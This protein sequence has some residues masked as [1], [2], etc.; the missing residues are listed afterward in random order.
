MSHEVPSVWVWK[1]GREK[2]CVCTCA[3]VPVHTF[4][5]GECK[6]IT[7]KVSIIKRNACVSA[8]SLMN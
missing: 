5:M 1:V 4:A 2:V 8:T 3:C 6:Y 7:N